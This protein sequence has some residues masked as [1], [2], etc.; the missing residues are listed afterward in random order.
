MLRGE[1]I[2]LDALSKAS[3]LAGSGG[4]AKLL[5]AAGSVRIDDPV[6]TRRGRKL[7]GGE[8]VQVGPDRVKVRMPPAAA[9]GTRRKAALGAIA[10][11][12]ERRLHRACGTPV[13]HPKSSVGFLSTPQSCGTRIGC[14]LLKTQPELPRA[15]ELQLMNPDSNRAS[16][17]A[18]TTRLRS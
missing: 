16:R 2:T 18:P 4:A 10:S 8:V 12:P 13:C 17:F 6:E 15:R 3:G 5:I 11:G 7:R 1:Y 9:A 14:K